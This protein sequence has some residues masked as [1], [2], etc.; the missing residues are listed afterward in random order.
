MVG[1]SVGKADSRRAEGR[2]RV[3]LL[4]TGTQLSELGDDIA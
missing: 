3:E 1:S 4:G 2:V